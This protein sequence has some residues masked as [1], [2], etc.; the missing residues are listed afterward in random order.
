ME[1]EKPNYK[2][3]KFRNSGTRKFQP[4][5]QQWVNRLWVV[6][7]CIQRYH[8]QHKNKELPHHFPQII[9]WVWGALLYDITHRQT[10]LFHKM[11]RATH[12]SIGNPTCIGTIRKVRATNNYRQKSLFWMGT[13]HIYQQFRSLRWRRRTLS[14]H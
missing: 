7:P 11:G 6:F 1:P 8:E 3:H 9:Q 13:R 5:L 2:T 14:E 4:G 10:Y 12:W